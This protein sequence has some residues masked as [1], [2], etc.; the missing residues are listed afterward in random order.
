VTDATGE[1]R[2]R[3]GGRSA[4]VRQSVLDATLEVLCD[5]GVDQ[6]AISEVASRAGVHE[7][8]IYR[9]WGT[10]ERL[11]IDAL[12]VV[13]EEVI[14]IPDTGSLRRDLVKFA[15]TIADLLATPLGRAIDQALSVPT[16]DPVIIDAC[17]AYFRSR[18]ESASTIIQR[19][20]ERGEIEA[21][22]DPSLAIEM[23]VAPLHLRHL[24][25]REPL[26]RKL[27]AQLADFVIHGLKG[28][29]WQ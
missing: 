10:R 26:G 7:T 5:R 29:S 9:R 15:K 21:C 6:F 2:Q 12:N 27:P 28:L 3:P 16:Q 19:A 20:I 11:M 1:V 23:L 4:R 25:S 18:F 13:G 8:S 24:M 22:T 14:P 17:A